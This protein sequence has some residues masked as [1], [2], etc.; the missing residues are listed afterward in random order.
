M[1][2][3]NLFTVGALATSLL[4]HAVIAADA[5]TP[6]TMPDAQKKEME[7]VIHDYLVANPEV[8]IEASQALQQKQQQNMQQ[9]AQSAIQ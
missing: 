4:S 9:Q 3:T 5:P 8:L 1:K 7:K 6:S 2:F